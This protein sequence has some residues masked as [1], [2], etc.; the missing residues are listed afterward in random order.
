[1]P[2]LPIPHLPPRAPD[3]HKGTYGHA[4]LV[5]GSRGMSGAISLAAVAALRSGA[6]LVTVGTPS[7][8]A[9]IVAGFEP[10]YMTAPLACDDEGR[11]TEAAHQRIVELATKCTSIGCGPGM[12]LTDDVKNLVGRL[13]VELPQPMVVDADALNALA[14]RPDWFSRHAAPRIVTPHPGEFARLAG[15]EKLNPAEREQ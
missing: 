2:S 7:A 6:G 10:S 4:L 15:I 12:Q 11:L 3:S 8:C 9:D 13:Y 14:T 5:G 1:M